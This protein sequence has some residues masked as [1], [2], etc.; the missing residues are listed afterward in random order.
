MMRIYMQCMVFVLLVARLFLWAP[1]VHAGPIVSVQNEALVA[2]DSRVSILKD[3]SARLTIDD[4]VTKDKQG[5]FHL[6]SL[7]D[8]APG[9]TRAAVWLA[10]NVRN[11]L[12]V[13]QER[14]IEVFPPR[15]RDVRLFVQ[16]HGRWRVLSSGLDV[17]VADRSIQSRQTVF[18]VTLAPGEV[19]KMYM[20][21]SSRNAMMISV[22]LWQ[23]EA[24]H[25]S[26]RKVD[27][28]N[29]IQFGA[30]F[31]FALY[32]LLLLFSA[33]D[34]VFLY[35]FGAMAAYGFYDVAILQYGSEF[36]W[37]GQPEWSMRSPGFFLS[38]AV[39]ATALLVSR[40]LQ[41]PRYFPWQGRV[42]VILA[43]VSLVLAPLHL[44]FP[45]DRVV[46][47]TN[48]LALVVVV[49]SLSL[50]VLAVWRRQRNAAWMLLAFVL[51][52]FTSLLR[53]AQIFGVIPNGVWGGYAQS[54]SMV[55][56]GAVMA[57]VMADVVRQLR[58]ERTQAQADMLAER[59]Q[60]TVRLQREV[61]ARTSE[62]VAAKEKAE[63]ASQAKSTFLAHM[64]HELR[65]PLHS[66]LGY[67]QLAM[68]N[69][70]S[71]ENLKRME[72]VHR[73]GRHL[74]ALIDG[75]LD[76]VRG[77]AGRLQLER[78]SA[79][80]QSLLE[81][82]I[83]EVMPLAKE[84][85]AEV[86]GVFGPALPPAV[87]VD[88]V[89]LQQVLTNLL[90][91]AC[92]HSQGR[93][94]SLEV[95]HIKDDAGANSKKAVLWFGVRDNGVG[96]PEAERQ[97][98]FSPFEQVEA[99]TSSRGVGLGLTIAHQLVT[100]MEGEL[101]CEANEGGGSL[102]WFQVAL[103]RA[104]ESEL[105]P[106]S[107]PL[108]LYRY[109]GPVRRILVVD[110]SAE[111]RAV[112]TDILASSGFDLAVVASGEE[113]LMRLMT[114][115]FDAV[116]IDQFVADLSHEHLLRRARAHG[117]SL[118]FLLLSTSRPGLPEDGTGQPLFTAV[119][120][121][122][123]RPERLLKT[124]GRELALA[125]GADVTSP[126]QV[127]VKP[128]QQWVR[129]TPEQLEPLRRAVELGQVTEVEEWIVQLR[130][131]QPDASEFAQL[132]QDAIRR[133]D[134]AFIRRLLKE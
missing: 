2:L 128:P 108:G 105:V 60:S 73:R 109:D 62:L 64:S 3:P 78:R 16:E 116:L 58:L 112:L 47:V 15:L 31:L 88:A 9:Y 28:V 67:S 21:I 1:S 79:Y 126:R 42:L 114:E 120:M 74:L 59:V 96:I 61:E 6:A 53:V 24:F 99:T 72:A 104:D 130:K 98:V 68:E 132:V 134:F 91:N 133:L 13:T 8:L 65:T 63:T 25:A 7:D 113:A 52:W 5:E 12:P 115:P 22:R 127:S 118:P 27:L 124:L 101:V 50:S 83:E 75:L 94:I 43:G 93:H 34:L 51:L 11:D 131:S 82:A 30:I 29:G 69:A 39:A 66:I 48:A 85:G 106:V 86:L 129:P 32:S 76:Y 90:V 33:R 57:G 35:F 97:R 80:F 4:V 17:A 19:R 123:V 125:W 102:F 95:R 36:L 87:R 14:L 103:E 55:V 81:S 70:L 44:L 49:V 111:T 41:I 77:E 92:R 37:S 45:Y 89:R 107:G 10:I 18:P 84:A 20:R 110:D 100:L 26:E 121:K 38:V 71:P 119:L 46:P 56:S 54:W 117:L 122:P 23:S 40:L